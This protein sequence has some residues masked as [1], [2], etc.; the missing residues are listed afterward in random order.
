MKLTYFGK[1]QFSEFLGNFLFPESHWQ[2]CGSSESYRNVNNVRESRS[3]KG[4][5]RNCQYS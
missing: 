4:C 3:H 1:T 2:L 5:E